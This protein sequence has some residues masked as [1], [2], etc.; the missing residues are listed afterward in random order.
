MA[1]RC[2]P[3]PSSLQAARVTAG[4]L[5]SISWR[6][7]RSKTGTSHPIRNVFVFVGADPETEWL[8]SCGVVLDAHGFVVTGKAADGSNSQAA[9]TLE[10]SVAGIFAVGDV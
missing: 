9:A 10:S 2:D 8:R 7:R 3:A 1:E 4:R 6:D 5:A